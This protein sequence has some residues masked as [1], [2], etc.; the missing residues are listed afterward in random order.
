MNILNYTCDEISNILNDKL[1]KYTLREINNQSLLIFMNDQNKVDELNVGN[2]ISTFNSI[3]WNCDKF[4]FD[5]LDELKPLI[6]SR[7]LYIDSNKISEETI[8]AL[9]KK[10]IVDITKI[11]GSVY[12]HSIITF[13]N[14][15]TRKFY[16]KD[17]ILL[18]LKINNKFKLIDN[19]KIELLDDE[20]EEVKRLNNHLNRIIRAF[21]RYCP[22]I[23][24]I[25][26]DDAII[27]RDFKTREFK[28]N[29]KI[30]EELMNNIYNC[31]EK[32]VFNGEKVFS[33][34]HPIRYCF[35][36]ALLNNKDKLLIVFSAF[37][38]DEP[39]YN[40][41][42]TLKTCDC[43]KLFIL[44]DYGSKG[45]YY[46]G[47]QGEFTIETSVMSLISYIMSKN[48]I[49]YNNVTT[50]GSSKGGTA[51]L[52][53]G[54]KYN[55]ANVI[56]GAPQYKIGTYLSDLS[57]DK[58][59]IEIFGGINEQNRIKYNNLIRLVANS[60]TNIYL[61]TSDG[62]NQ[63]KKVLKEFEYVANELNLKLY[64]DKCD[65]KNHGEISKEFPIYIFKKLDLILDKGPINFNYYSKDIEIIKKIAKK[66]IRK[67]KKGD[68]KL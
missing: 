26:L 19:E 2:K 25:S 41:I 6:K 56:V 68:K 34:I 9:P 60:N 39:K 58:Y 24:I 37:S 16:N 48:N 27:M 8:K 14:K 38:S 35:E 53:Y 65:I 36:K 44:D 11:H 45:S 30:V 33:S 31:L 54:M 63:Y 7:E 49:N 46:F 62:D 55:F 64:L 15:M 13:I 52:Y 28:I 1:N 43:N 61:L 29:Y 22:S 18:D 57:I 10:K 40:Y 23:N 47:L 32:K 67:I 21:K 4:I 42:N 59:A 12:K 17:I 3:D 51:A 50:I 5:I 20:K 66:F